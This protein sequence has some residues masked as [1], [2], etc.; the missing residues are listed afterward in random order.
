[1]SINLCAANK[2]TGWCQKCECTVEMDHSYDPICQEYFTSHENY[3][4]EDNEWDWDRY[5][6]DGLGEI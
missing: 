1:M 2:K 5:N 6:G 4:T 3:V